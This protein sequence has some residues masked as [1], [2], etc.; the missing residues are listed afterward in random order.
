MSVHRGCGEAPA[1]D[2]LLAKI[3]GY[4]S[5]EVPAGLTHHEVRAETGLLTMLWHHA[6]SQNLIVTCPGALGGLLGPSDGL[7]AYVGEVMARA[8]MANV[9]RLDWRHRND[10]ASCTD[11]VLMTLDLAS[12]VGIRNAALIAH[13]FG[14]VPAVR[15]AGART[16]VVV[17]VATLATQSAGYEIAGCLDGVDL[18]CLH[19]DADTVL[20]ARCSQQIAEA[21]NG[22]AVLL[23]GVG[24]GFEECTTELRQILSQWLGSLFS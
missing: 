13:S 18:L 12:A 14:G 8:G 17:G 19:G 5:V 21:G 24:H 3:V 11:D 23:E 16:G 20:P 9:I 10:I 1:R 4:Q 22:R 2:G 15:A 7:Y 6:D